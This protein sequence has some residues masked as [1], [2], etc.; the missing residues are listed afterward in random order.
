MNDER[1]HHDDERLSSEL[2]AHFARTEPVPDSVLQAARAAIEL[3]DLD[4]QLADL[5]A[6]SS[7]E[8]KELAGVRGG[9]HRLLTFGAGDRFVEVDVAV[10]DDEREMRGYV[11]PG[12]GGSIAV[13]HANGQIDV[14]IDQRGRF[15]VLGVPRGPVRF[16]IAI[17]GHPLLLTPWL[18]M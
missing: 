2:Q 3:L 15:R 10:L 4:A 12:A 16:R 5:L 7:A 9:A 6:D 1:H 13:E 18:P 8:S 17:A 11:V 14:P